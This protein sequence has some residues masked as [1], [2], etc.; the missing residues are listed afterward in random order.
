MLLH[1]IV[2][3]PGREP[4]QRVGVLI[5]SYVDVSSKV[6]PHRVYFQTCEA[7]AGAGF[8]ALRFDC[9]G[10]CD[11]PGILKPAL[12]ERIADFRAAAAF[13]RSSYRLDA[14]VGWGLC[15][16][17]TLLLHCATTSSPEE[18]RF[19]GLVLCNILGDPAVVST[20]KDGDLLISARRIFLNGSPL[21]K[22]LQLPR[23]FHIYRQNLPKL[24]AKL[25]K[26][27]TKPQAEY[28][29]IRTAASRVQQLLAQY[30]KPTQIICAAKDPCQKE[31]IKWKNGNHRQDWVVM[32][33]AD[34]VFASAEQKARLIHH[35]LEW[36]EKFRMGNLPNLQR[37]GSGPM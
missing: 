10:L 7:M 20:F 36:L 24:A 1:G 9:R 30:S 12:S 5:S 25:F 29:E 18:E 8:Y 21:Q 3:R 33:D 28:E 15:G 35:T 27:Y 26:R 22:L 16:G 2:H 19:D 37:R 6:G 17:A 13:F 34:H 31:V 11:S 23:K 14:L 32:E 4:S